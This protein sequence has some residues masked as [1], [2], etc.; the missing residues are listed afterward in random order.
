VAERFECDFCKRWHVNS[1][2][3]AKPDR[4]LAISTSVDPAGIRLCAA[5]YPGWWNGCFV[6]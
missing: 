4:R 6:D 2:E 5:A 3:A 1:I